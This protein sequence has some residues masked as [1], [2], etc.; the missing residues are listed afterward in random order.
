VQRTLLTA[1]GIANLTL[2]TGEPSGRQSGK[3]ALFSQTSRGRG[4]LF[5]WWREPTRPVI[6]SRFAAFPNQSAGPACLA[7]TS[8]AV[9]RWQIRAP[10]VIRVVNMTENP[11]KMPLRTPVYIGPAESEVEQ[12][13]DF[14]QNNQRSAPE[15]GGHRRVFYVPECCPGLAP[16]TF[17][18]FGDNWQAAIPAAPQRPTGK[19]P[20]GLQMED[21]ACSRCPG[22]SLVPFNR[23]SHNDRRSVIWSFDEID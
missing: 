16:A 3:P 8:A 19:E 10:N 15:T 11:A 22:E 9:C 2:Q 20:V 13:T 5:V 6:T 14:S 17:R 1:G 7:E 12:R 23:H 21:S 4:L 18:E